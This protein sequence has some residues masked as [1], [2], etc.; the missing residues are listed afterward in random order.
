MPIVAREAVEIPTD[1]FSGE[2][3]KTEITS[4]QNSEG[5]VVQYVQCHVDTGRKDIKGW[6][7]LMK[8]SVPAYLS[9]NSALGKLLARLGIAIPAAGQQFDE[10]TLT[11]LSVTF[12]T[13]RDGNFTNVVVDSIVPADE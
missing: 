11:G 5:K 12:Q 8:F 9:K 7:G 13:R 10:Q 3:V 6:N 4:S 1:D 2:I